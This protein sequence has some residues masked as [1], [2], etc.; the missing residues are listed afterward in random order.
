MWDQVWVSSS[1]PH[2]CVPYPRGRERERVM[3]EDPP[4]TIV[5]QCP[6][7]RSKIQDPTSTLHHSSTYG[8][9]PTC[10]LDSGCD[11]ALENLEKIFILSL[12]LGFGI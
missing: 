6:D 8:R 5:R 11:R 9:R 1:S 3:R 10:G 2:P 12:D 7:P 4:Y